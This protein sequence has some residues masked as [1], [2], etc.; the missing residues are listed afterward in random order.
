MARKAKLDVLD[1]P[2]DEQ[3]QGPPKDA[4]ASEIEK[5]DMLK[6]KRPDGKFSFSLKAYVRKPLFWIAVVSVVLLASIA[7]MS[8]RIYERQDTVTPVVQGGHA[9]SQGIVPAKGEMVLL[10]GFAVD[11]TDG[12]D[13]MRIAF[14]DIALEPEKNQAVE[15]VRNHSGTRNLIYNIMRSKKAEE[16][17]L[18]ELRTGL[19]TELK[20]ELNGLFGE[21]L[22]KNVYFSRVEVI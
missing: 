15:A 4:V 2:I 11:M 18:P 17:L 9:A 14:C 22:V 8:I 10:T 21:E 20:R 19:K 6:G 1:I 5:V 13:N 12:K 16:L 7:G 3:I